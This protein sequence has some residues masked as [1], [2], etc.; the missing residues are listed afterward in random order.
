VHPRLMVNHQSRG[1]VAGGIRSLYSVPPSPR[2]GIRLRP[3][4]KLRAMA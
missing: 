2:E 4:D 1:Y 3:F